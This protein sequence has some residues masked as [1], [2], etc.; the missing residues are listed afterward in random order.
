MMGK[1]G[2]NGWGDLRAHC[3]KGVL[4]TNCTMLLAGVTLL[5]GHI[6]QKVPQGP[7]VQTAS[8]VWR[9][10]A[11]TGGNDCRGCQVDCKAWAL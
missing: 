10:E 9:L 8:K 3:K 4:G 7:I 1:L 5:K 2:F 11:L 6:L